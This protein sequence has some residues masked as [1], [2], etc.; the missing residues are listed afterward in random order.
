MDINVYID[1][2]I[3]RSIGGKIYGC[4]H[5]KCIKGSHGK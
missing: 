3:V 2:F 5:D 1:V 4:K